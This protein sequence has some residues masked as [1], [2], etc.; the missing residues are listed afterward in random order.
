MRL[1]RCFYVGALA[2]VAAVAGPVCSGQSSAIGVVVAS[3]NGRVNDIDAQPGSNFYASEQFITREQGSM[4]LRA[5]DCRI[6]LGANTNVH[7][8]P[9][10]TRDHLVAV[11]GTA[12]YRCPAGASFWLETPAG[13]VRAA[14][15]QP[16]SGMVVINDA[17]NLVISADGGDLVLDTDGELHLVKAGQSYRVAVMEEETAQTSSGSNADIQRP[18]PRR[19]RRKIAMWLIG[20][21]AVAVVSYEI[22]HSGA[23]SASKP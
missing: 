23:E 12:R 18:G 4:E 6:Y 21:G 14:E 11:A 5:H 7:F 20:G 19:P 10:S 1:S 15:G 22:W 3:Q 16:G 2:V 13:I 17:H 9:D 8:L